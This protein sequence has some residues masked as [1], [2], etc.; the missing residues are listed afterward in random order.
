V[1][2]ENAFD[3]RYAS[4]LVINATRNRSFEP[5]LPRRVTFLLAVSWR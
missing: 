2:L 3:R 4:S 1:S 5:G